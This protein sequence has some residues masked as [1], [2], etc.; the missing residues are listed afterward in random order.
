MLLC[1]ELMFN[2]HARGYGR[3]GADL[4]VVPRAAGAAHSRWKTAA[5]MAAIV[6]GSFVVSSSRVGN[7]SP[8]PTFGGCGY[9]FGP[10]GD[11]IS[12]T[13]TAEQLIV[14]GIDVKEAERQKQEYPCYV[15]E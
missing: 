13:S 10:R 1:T 7:A 9:A 11:L 15:V 12:E 2:E 3:A 14:A 8:G 4:I 6:S 5:S